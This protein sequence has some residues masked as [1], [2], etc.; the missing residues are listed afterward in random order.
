MYAFL[1]LIIMG[2]NALGC[3]MVVQTMSLV[4]SMRVLSNKYLL[5]ELFIKQILIINKRRFKL[6]NK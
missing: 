2:L 6:V 1:L 5:S 4:E 3:V